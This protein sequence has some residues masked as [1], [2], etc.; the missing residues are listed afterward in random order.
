MK[1]ILIRIG[2]IMILFS[3]LFFTS[4]KIMNMRTFQIFGDL[5]H[6]VDTE[7]KVVAITFDDGPTKMVDQL[8][9]L[10]EK[11]KAKS[12]FFL[13][14]SDIEKYPEE[15]KKLVDAGHQIGNHTY[16]HQRMILKSPT[17]IKEEIE[18]TDDLIRQSG[19]QGEIDFRPPFGKKLFGLPFYLSKHNRETIM[20]SLEP[21]SYYESA[22]EK[23]K[24][25]VDSIKPGDIILLHPMYDTSG[26]ELKAVEGILDE[27]SQRGFQFVTVDE[28]Q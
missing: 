1:K 5:T 22:N 17:F 7:K 15:A 14:G 11:Y 13:I 6:Q 25:V 9:P 26:R 28:L 24:Y 27:L 18:K 2:F 21:D 16:S 20:W 8:L 23:I 10:L 19:Y 12:T 4:F 3:I